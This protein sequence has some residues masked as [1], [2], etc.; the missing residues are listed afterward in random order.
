[1]TVIFHDLIHK[2]LEDYVDDILVKYLNA[3]DHLSHL[4]EVFN[5]LAEYCLMLNPKKCVFGVASRKLL[6]FIVS[7]RGIE[8]DPKKFKA[9]MDMPPPR[10]LRHLRSLQGK[11]QSIQ[12]FISQLADKCQP[13]THLLKKDQNFRWD[14][15][16]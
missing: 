5:Q 10:T 2:I 6:G 12:R 14:P 4:E 7:R 3:L 9:I 1:M 8:I 11:L 13:F 16:C 15:A